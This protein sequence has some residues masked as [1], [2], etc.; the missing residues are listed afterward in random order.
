MLEKKKNPFV[1]LD[2]SVREGWCP[3]DRRR[4]GTMHYCRSCVCDV[5]F[6]MRIFLSLFFVTDVGL[7]FLYHLSLN[8]VLPLSCMSAWRAPKLGS[9]LACAIHIL[10]VE[11]MRLS[12]SDPTENDSAIF[13]WFWD[14]WHLSIKPNFG[15]LTFPRFSINIPTKNIFILFL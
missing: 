5:V 4:R 14:F 10:V 2:F 9:L 13:H 15:N 11:M 3:L 8:L 1:R 7:T 6:I 12:L